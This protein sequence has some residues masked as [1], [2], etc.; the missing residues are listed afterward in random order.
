MVA[1]KNSLSGC[2]YPYYRCLMY[3][4]HI[5]NVFSLCCIIYFL[6]CLLPSSTIKYYGIWNCLLMQI[7]SSNFFSN[8]KLYKSSEI[9]INRKN[10]FQNSVEYERSMNI[11]RM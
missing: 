6:T 5:F 4:I 7:R 3:D 1:L 2:I 9:G 8:Y 10:A 11:N